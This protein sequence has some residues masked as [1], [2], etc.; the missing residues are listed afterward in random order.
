VSRQEIALAVV[1]R[2]GRVLL[3]A[4]AEAGGLDG[5]WEFPGGKIEPGETPAEAAARELAEETGL[6]APRL[7]PLAP[8][9]A[10]FHDYPDRSVLLHA[11]VAEADAEAAADAS[12]TWVPLEAL[13]G[14]PV[15]DANLPILRA[16]R[17]RA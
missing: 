7:T 4:R 1:L 6:G 10:V 16:L 9:V 13:P 2:G 5:A 14:L 15:P 12:W 17:F 8:L 11:F 3:R